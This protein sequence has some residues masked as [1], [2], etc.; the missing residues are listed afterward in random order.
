[1]AAP[2]TYARSLKKFG[3]ATMMT[4]AG[5]GPPVVYRNCLQ[6][7]AGPAAREWRGKLDAGRYAGYHGRCHVAVTRRD[8]A[9]PNSPAEDSMKDHLF[10][11][12]PDAPGLPPEVLERMQEEAKR[13][14]LRM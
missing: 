7:L 1:M 9:H 12:T 14:F 8:G 11:M 3:S 6:R 4:A 10:T 2:N 13:N 5:A